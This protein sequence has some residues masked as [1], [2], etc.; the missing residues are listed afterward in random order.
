MTLHT[1]ASVFLIQWSSVTSGNIHTVILVNI[2]TSAP[3]MT[4]EV[5]ESHS[6]ARN[7]RR[8]NSLRREGAYD[9]FR[10][11]RRYGRMPILGYGKVFFF[12]TPKSRLTRFSL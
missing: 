7:L 3:N 2:T 5:I 8:V 12:P 10:I 11:H 4:N 9:T 6:Y 1:N